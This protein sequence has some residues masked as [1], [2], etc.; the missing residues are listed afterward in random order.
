MIPHRLPAILVI[1][2]LAI[3]VLTICVLTSALPPPTEA[4]QTMWLP[5]EE[6]TSISFEFIK[7]KLEQESRYTFWTSA[8][9]VSGRVQ[10]TEN[11][12]VVFDIP[13]AHL[14]FDEEFS[15]WGPDGGTSLGNPYMGAEYISDDYDILEFGMRI[16]VASAD[17]SG[18]LVWGV[19]S[20]RERFEAFLLD[21][22]TV[23]F[24]YNYKRA[25][26]AG[27][28][29]WV[30]GGPTFLIG[31][32]GG[33]SEFLADYGFMG[34]YSKRRLEV[35]GGVTGK[36]LLTTGEGLAERS[37]HHLGVTGS[38]DTGRVRPGAAIRIPLDEDLGRGVSFFW[39]LNVTVHFQ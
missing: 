28:A 31:T 11:W 34:G 25:W 33:G 10:A 17:D 38:Y 15:A 23:Q 32:S 24:V 18:G 39:T 36:M 2:L 6:R 29:L 30:R 26:E 12:N 22:A 37:F 7:T 20:D 13:F 19:I 14:G 9:F 1:S 35:I 8:W 16:P 5:R 27:G 3:S 21:T 4:A